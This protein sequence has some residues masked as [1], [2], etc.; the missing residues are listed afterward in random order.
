VTAADQRQAGAAGHYLCVSFSPQRRALRGEGHQG[1]VGR[2][3][4]R[5]P[6]ATFSCL[7]AARPTP[8]DYPLTTDIAGD[9]AA[10]RCRRSSARCTTGSA[11]ASFV[12]QREASL[13]LLQGR[14]PSRRSCHG[15]RQV[16]LLSAAGACAA[17]V[18]VVVS[19]LIALMKDQVD[20]LR[21]RASSGGAPLPGFLPTSGPGSS[22]HGVG[23]VQLLYIRRSGWAIRRSGS[24]PPPAGRRG[25]W[26]TRPTASA[27]GGT[28]SSRLTTPS[29]VRAAWTCRRRVHRTGHAGCPGGHRG[30]ARTRGPLDLIT[31]FERPT[32]RLPWR[33]SRPR[34]EAA[35][36][37]D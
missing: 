26:W 17:G 35:A 8:L 14:E 30:A 4:A 37:C 29:R 10:P 12:R 15:R 22:G 24:A 33:P 6:P 27:I 7:R 11:C 23:R 21:A 1:A 31:G 25:W 28:I 32:S 19:P 16:A 20:K 9:R 18:T 2:C 3:G 13:A 36:L 5:R 34:R